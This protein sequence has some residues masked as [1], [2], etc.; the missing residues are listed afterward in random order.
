MQIYEAVHKNV[1]LVIKTNLTNE[2]NNCGQVFFRLLLKE[3]YNDL[4]IRPPV[5]VDV[6]S[7]S[8]IATYCLLVNYYLITSLQSWQFILA[9]VLHAIS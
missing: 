7:V 9:C 8:V 4:C 5:R 6:C 1:K 3:G 2:R